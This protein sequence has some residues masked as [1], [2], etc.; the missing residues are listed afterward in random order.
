MDF[1][2]KPN[3]SFIYLSRYQVLTNP[4]KR[5]ITWETHYSGEVGDMKT[6]VGGGRD[7]KGLAY[8]V[9]RRGTTVGRLYAI[10]GE[11]Q[12][13]DPG[14]SE[15][16]PLVFY[17]RQHYNDNAHPCQRVDEEYDVMHAHPAKTCDQTTMPPPTTQ[18]S[19]I[20]SQKPILET[21]IAGGSTRPK[22]D[23]Y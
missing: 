12:F 14:D 3:S 9:A 23:D 22:G 2:G 8:Y 1:E 6:V 21:T 7:S 5:A 15:L 10:E 17:Y 18:S 19:T 11:F 13:C 20:T 16:Y 4:N